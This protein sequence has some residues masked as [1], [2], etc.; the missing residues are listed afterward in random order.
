M[1]KA[2]PTLNPAARLAITLL[3]VYRL[4]LSPWFANRCRFHPS[5]SHYAEEAI[6]HHGFLRGTCLAL[7][8]LSRCHP[9]HEGGW[10]PVPGKEALSQNTCCEPPLVIDRHK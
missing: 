4:L 5:C 6:R 8:R 3:H 1:A 9:W 7:R 2:D 10:D